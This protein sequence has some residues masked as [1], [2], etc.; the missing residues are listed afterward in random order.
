[1]Q[2]ADKHTAIKWIQ[3]RI[4][5]QPAGFGGPQL[6]ELVVDDEFEENHQ[7]EEDLEGMFIF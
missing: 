2:N 6:I 3:C 1:M 5:D 7:S 4:V